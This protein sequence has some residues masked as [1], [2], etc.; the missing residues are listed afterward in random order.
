[1][2]PT[3]GSTHLSGVD[4]Q[5]PSIARVYDYALGGKDWFEIDRYVYDHLKN[6]VP[7]QDDVR[8]TNRRWLERVVR[9]LT[10]DV[11]IG[12]ILDLG[13]GLPTQQNTHQIAQELDA[14][15]VVVYVDN[16]PVC[17]ARGR[18]LLQTNER[19]HFLDLD[20]TQPARVL[21]DPAVNRYLDLDQPLLLMQC[22]TLHH[23][24]DDGDPA[25][26]MREYIRRLPAGSYV[27]ISH[28]FDPGEEDQQLH[29]LARQAERALKEEGLGTG[30]WRT[31]E[32]LQPFF[33]GLELV[34]LGWWNSTTGGRP[35]PR[36]AHSR[37][38]NISSSAASAAKHNPTTRRRPICDRRIRRIR[39]TR[40]VPSSPTFSRSPASTLPRRRTA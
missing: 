30:R 23:V 8:A 20:L 37:P 34:P 3:D 15:V 7:H 35:D 22:A 27:M 6:V 21:E 39:T 13:S 14:E 26:L 10:R 18:E 33:E 19:T 1:M 28:F 25:G 2:A 9:Y 16:D 38:T 32:E 11:G 24:D 31:R 40:F 29:N 5:L 17:V 36:C 4:P 12:Q